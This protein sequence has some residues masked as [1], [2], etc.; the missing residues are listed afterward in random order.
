LNGAINQE[1]AEKAGADT[2]LTKFV[3][4]ELARAVVDG[5]NAISG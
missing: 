3:P 4:L 2:V 1:K 5:I